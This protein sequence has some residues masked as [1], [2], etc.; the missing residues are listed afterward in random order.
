L[1]KALNKAAI[2]DR[3]K[4][5]NEA[6]RQT[7]ELK[8]VKLVAVSSIRPQKMSDRALWRS[9]FSPKQKKRLPMA[10]MPVL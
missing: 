9:W 6:L 4:T 8:V 5:L 7:L 3:Q 2:P 10:Y 1:N